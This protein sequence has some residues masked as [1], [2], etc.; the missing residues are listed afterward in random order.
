MVVIA[1]TSALLLSLI[2]WYNSLLVLL[3]RT[4]AL[5]ASALAVLSIALL[6]AL[7]PRSFTTV[8]PESSSSALSHLLEMMHHMIAS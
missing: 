3:E 8:V 6:S 1:S 2:L 5:A 4:I 7:P